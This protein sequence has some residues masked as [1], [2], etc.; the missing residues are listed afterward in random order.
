MT[1]QVPTQND[2][3]I[4]ELQN[5]VIPYLDLISENVKAQV[6]NWTDWIDFWSIDFN[7]KPEIFNNMW[8]SFR[9]PKDRELK[10]ISS[11]FNYENTGA[12]TISVKIIDIMGTNTIQNYEV[13]I[14]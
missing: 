2:E 4:V 12:Y 6:T 9:T 10:L 1:V 14:K 7:Y 3:V 11:P 13:N 8:V 5:Y